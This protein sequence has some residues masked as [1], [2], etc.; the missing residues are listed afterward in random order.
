MPRTI[1]DEDKDDDCGVAFE[2]VTVIRASPRALLVDLGEYGE[3][4]IPHSCVHVDSPVYVDEEQRIQGS[5]DTLINA[6]WFAAK[7]GLTQ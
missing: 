6:R 4:W 3:Q 2:N 5:P 1:H 7:E